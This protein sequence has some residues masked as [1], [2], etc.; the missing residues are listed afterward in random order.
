MHLR[1]PR[2][3]P[4][5]AWVLALACGVL[6]ADSGD[7]EGSH[8]YAGFP[9]VAGFVISDYDEDKPAEFDFPVSRPLPEDADHLEMIHLRGHRYI[10]RYDL[11]SRESR[12]DLI[13]NAAVLRKARDQCRI[14][15]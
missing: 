11:R 14:H 1:S 9:R 7:V 15:H 5:V 8:D 6:R 10:I 13:S 12:P 2:L 4:Q 3:L